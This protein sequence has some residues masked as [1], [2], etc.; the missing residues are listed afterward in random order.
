M[1]SGHRKCLSERWGEDEGSVPTTGLSSGIPKRKETQE[2]KKGVW[3]KEKGT[4]ENTP[5]VVPVISNSSLG[6]RTAQE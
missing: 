3:E 2:K 5:D 6:L 4:G 1:G